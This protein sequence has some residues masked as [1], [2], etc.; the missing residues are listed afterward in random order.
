MQKYEVPTKWRLLLS[1]RKRPL[2]EAALQLSELR[3]SN[4]CSFL[5]HLEWTQELQAEL[6]ILDYSIP[7]AKMVPQPDGSLYLPVAGLA[8]KRPSVL[9]GDRVVAHK[10][11]D[12]A[13]YRGTVT[14]VGRDGVSVRFARKFHSSF[15]RGEACAIQFQVNRFPARR[16]HQAIE[17]IKNEESS[18]NRLTPSLWRFLNEQDTDDVLIP[19]LPVPKMWFNSNL[20][21]RQKQAIIFITQ[22]PAS[23]IPYIV[24]GPAGTGKTTTIIESIKQLAQNSENKILVTAPSNSAADLLVQRLARGS[25][26]GKKLF[27]LNAV[28][29]AAESVPEDIREYCHTENTLWRVPPDF[30]SKQIIVSTCISAGTLYGLGVAANHFTHVFIDEAAQATEQETIASFAGMATTAKL[31][32]SGDPR[33]LGPIVSSALAK[34]FGMD[35][36][37]LERLFLN[38]D[39]YRRDDR[40]QHY[41]FYCPLFLTK[42]VDNYRSHPNLLKLPSSMFY[43][44]ELQPKA[45]KVETTMFSRWEHLKNPNVPLIFHNVQGKDEQEG[46]SPSFF[47]TAEVSTLVSYVQKILD[48]K[49]VRPEDIGII[50]PY[51]KQCAKIRSALQST[52]KQRNDIARKITVGSV[53][54][55]QG[56]E[57]RVILISTV[58]SSTEWFGHDARFN[59]GFLKNAKRL[60]V[61]I[62]RAKALLVVVGN[63][64]ILKHDPNWRTLVKYAVDN[65]CYEGR[66]V[67]LDEDEPDVLDLLGDVGGQEG[68]PEADATLDIARRPTDDI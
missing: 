23:T 68:Q 39:P 30:E 7:E 27:R 8:E 55:F 20:N 2:R 53:E 37:L 45:D 6:E 49:G 15:I 59:L 54:V 42:L 26:F 14:F 67:S 35:I 21:D 16:C 32:L 58:R 13:G 5:Q 65:G 22:A 1:D 28:Y 24:Y 60:N 62:T 18:S 57:R 11:G 56:Q 31:V 43:D 19:D 29:R 12:S 34:Q 48:F 36:S 51:N 47:N 44:D 38:N 61:S 64:E 25:T 33:Q 10:R 40:Y 9:R 4:Y 50:S 3:R 46:N 63:A 41:G 66:A 52:F 17:C